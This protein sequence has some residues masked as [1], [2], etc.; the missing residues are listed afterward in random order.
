MKH[1]DLSILIPARNE[2]FLSRTVED[3]LKNKQGKT[4]I[5]VGLDGQWADPAI[6]DHPDVLIFYSPVS[7]GQRGMTNQ[8]C[9]LSNAKYVMK[10]DAHCALDEGFDVKL[11]AKMQ[12]NYTMV[13][14]MRNLHAFDWVCIGKK[15]P[16]ELSI[17]MVAVSCGHRIYQGPTP[18]KCEKCGG[19][20]KREVVWKAKD[21]PK[22]TSFR[23]DK[24]LHFQYF[25]EFRKRDAGK[26]ELHDGLTETLS[27]QG[28]CFLL[29]RDKYWELN[30]CD[31][32]FGSWGQQG[33]E[34]ACKT[35]LSGGRV[36]CNHDTWYAHMFRTQG[37]DFGFPYR[38]KQSQIEHA[39]EYSRE[40]FMQDKWPQAKHTFQWLLD[41]FYPVP[42]WHDEKNIVDIGMEKIKQN[43][44]V[45]ELVKKELEPSK[46]IL[47][48]TDNRVPV[49]LGHAVKNQ[50]LKA[51]IPITAVSLKPM[52]FGNNRIY[53]KAKRGYLTMAKQILAGLEESTADII[54]FAEHDVMYHP[55]HFDF[56][57]P[58]KDTYYY[59]TN[60]WRVRLADGHSLWCDDLQQ[61]SGLV[62]YRETLLTHYKKRVDILETVFNNSLYG[63]VDFDKYVREM[64]HEPGTHNRELRVDNLKAENFSS[65]FPNLDIRHENNATPSRWN[66]EQFRNEKYTRGW[67]EKY[68]S[69]IDGWDLLAL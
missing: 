4:Q 28:S 12:D 63:E 11:L 62:A 56:I 19:Q 9:R 36:V 49:R 8:L 50:L 57:P 27:I 24:T 45:H 69:E 65:Q 26:P 34:V 39:R 53:M 44:I 10:L 59:N 38:Q 64:G 47:F 48:Y 54:Y 25:N 60:V 6:P 40:L 21:S 32:E 42:E 46:Q 14:V 67:T 35:W 20:M 61:L 66:K 1:Y 33:V 52:N 30:I 37:G 51:N 15:D 41:K 22:S 16:S 55:S 17:D 7:L 18:E 13:P 58:K 3:L 5:I 43:N 23:F 31:E 2:M 29:T 68:V